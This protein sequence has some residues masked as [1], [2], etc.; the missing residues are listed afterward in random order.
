MVKIVRDVSC[1]ESAVGDVEGHVAEGQQLEQQQDEKQQRQPPRHTV[2][3]G[4][5]VIER[6]ACASKTHYQFSHV[7][8]CLFTCWHIGNAEAAPRHRTDKHQLAGPSCRAAPV[9]Q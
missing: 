5:Q 4:G 6:Q 2:W 1:E 3:A 8:K 7:G 9:L